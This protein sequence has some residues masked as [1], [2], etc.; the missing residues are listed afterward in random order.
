MSQFAKI[1]ATNKGR[2][3]KIAKQAY[4]VTVQKVNLRSPVDTGLFKNNWFTALN[5][6]SQKITA[7]IGGAFGEP[8]SNSVDDAIGIK[9]NIGETLFLTNSLPYADR[10]EY[11]WSDQ[12]P[13]GMVRISAGEWTQT[14]NTVIRLTK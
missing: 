8:Q 10:L 1:A 13:Q 4:I 5:T 14:V 3:K 11:G 12:A 6:P 7:R 9:F 2:M